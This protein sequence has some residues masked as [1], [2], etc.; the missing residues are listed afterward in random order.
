MHD[1]W[2]Q[3]PAESC[4]KDASDLGLGGEVLASQ[5]LAAVWLKSGV[6]LYSKFHMEGFVGSPTPS[7]YSSKVRR[8]ER[9]SSSYSCLFLDAGHTCRSWQQC[10]H[11]ENKADDNATAEVE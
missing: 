9:G 8:M 10:A 6:K 7:K 4:K 5:N 2:I 1:V 11:S 3:I